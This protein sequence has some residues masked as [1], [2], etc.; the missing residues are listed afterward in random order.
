MSQPPHVNDV[1]RE[2]LRDGA[3]SYAARGIVVE[4]DLR[5]ETLLATSER[6][7]ETALYT[8][9]R[10]LPA[11]LAPGARLR[12]STRDRAGGDIELSWL[13]EETRAAGD[14]HAHPLAQDEAYGDLLEL[15]LAGLEQF[16]R[17]R[18]GHVEVDE[19]SLQGAPGV[20]RRYFFL[21]PNFRREPGWH[22]VRRS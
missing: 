6:V 13:A 17:A 22:P 12:I 9:F 11:R 5:G 7:L 19:G 4:E 8:I 20:H 2:A 16:C 14:G 15:A 3:P 18:S 21:L 10:G 1:I